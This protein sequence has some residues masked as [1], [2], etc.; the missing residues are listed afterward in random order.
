MKRIYFILFAVCLCALASAQNK[1]VETFDKNTW[2]WT[3]GS[4]KYQS[5]AIEDGLLVISN[6]QKNKKATPYQSLAKSFA[7]LP[8]RP[9]ANFKITIKYY[10]PNYNV[11]TY[12]IYF[13]TSKDCLQEDIETF[14][15]CFLTA[16]GPLYY[17]GI[18][19]ESSSNRFEKLPGKVKAKGEYPMEFV[20]EKK[21]RNTIIELNGVQIYEGELK[22]TNPCIGFAVPFF[23]KNLSYIKIDEIIIEQADEED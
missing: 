10:V 9:N 8:F 4:D 14:E 5:V 13:N 2:H 20:I 7:K 11:C 16:F 21:S 23:K 12:N 18:L 1:K 3:E 22:F 19:G 6:L 17:L 15:S